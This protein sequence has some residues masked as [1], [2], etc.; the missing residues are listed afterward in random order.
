MH[1]DLSDRYTIHCLNEENGKLKAEIERLRPAL[2]QCAN[3]AEE[4]KRGPEYG[5]PHIAA[6]NE[7]CDQIAKA[8]RSLLV[9]D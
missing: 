2:W 3:V 7:A 1:P 8:I 9:A 6:H 5:R 4:F